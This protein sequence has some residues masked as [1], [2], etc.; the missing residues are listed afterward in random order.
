MVSLHVPIFSFALLPVAPVTAATQMARQPRRWHLGIL[1]IHVATWVEDVP[2]DDGQEHWRRFQ[3][4]QQRLILRQGIA[5]AKAC[6]KLNEPINDADGDGDH[7]RVQRPRHPSP[8]G[9]LVQG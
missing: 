3:N 2:D 7:A 8:A 4:I 9:N 6:G 1:A 5:G